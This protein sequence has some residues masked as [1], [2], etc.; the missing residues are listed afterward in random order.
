MMRMVAGEASYQSLCR[1]VVME[2]KEEKICTDKQRRTDEAEL[3][4]DVDFA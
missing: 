1:C 3:P 4:R 2:V